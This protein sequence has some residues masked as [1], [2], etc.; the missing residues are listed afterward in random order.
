MK[1]VLPIK[2]IAAVALCA[3]LLAGC[4]SS[5]GTTAS[6]AEPAE[7]EEEDVALA[8]EPEQEEETDAADDGKI[9]IVDQLGKTIELD[10]VPE[11]ICTTIMPFPYIFYAVAGNCDNLIGCNPS[12]IVAYNDSMLK[13]TYPELA[14]ASTDFVDTSFIVNVEELIKLEPDV[15]FQW[16]YMD[17][18]IEKM[19]AAGIK[20]I[21]LQ[22]GTID[23]L[24]TWIRI[25]AK[26][27][28]KEA[29]GEELIAYFH[30][31]VA[32]VDEKIAT[33]SEDDYRDIMILAYDN[34][35]IDGSSGFSKY[36]VEHS[37]ANNVALG[38]K[39]D[40]TMVNMEQIYEW[41]PEIIYIGNF[42]S[43]VPSDLMNNTIEGQ[44]WSVLDA[45]QNDEV[46]KIPIGG[47][48]W[49]PPGVETP[50]MIKW[51]AK[52]Q[53]PDL[54]ADM[55]MEEEVRKFYRDV[56]DYELNDAEM[57]EL[58]GDTKR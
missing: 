8:E 22:Y 9:V 10:G 38:L 55:D 6:Q 35:E 5:A 20:V 45:V 24:E 56:Y 13:Y 19:E 50:L 51:L 14:N 34:L 31:T 28:D 16:N 57:E 18:E 41:N 37:G 49:D 29:R 26:M 58:L 33:L 11:R 4:S 39:G 17:D 25:I 54:F 52:T 40:D 42:T 36:W 43:V 47:Y 1:K 2:R 53:H 48:R 21:A 15:V 23:D 32:E 44:D 46:Y 30:D 27:M 7:I 3:A 12:S